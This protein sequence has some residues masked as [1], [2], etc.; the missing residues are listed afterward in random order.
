MGSLSNPMSSEFKCKDEG[1]THDVEPQF[2]ENLLYAQPF[3]AFS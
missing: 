1:V 2:I 3:Q